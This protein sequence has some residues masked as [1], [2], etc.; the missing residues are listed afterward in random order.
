MLTN[1][2][3]YIRN[4]MILG[5]LT[6]ILVISIIWWIAPYF[7]MDSIDSIA[8]RWEVLWAALAIS[9][10]P[11]VALIAR[12]ASLRFFG[13]A[14]DGDHLD[15][16]VELDARV[17]NNTYEQYL[18]FAIALFGLTIGLP[19]THLAMPILLAVAFDFYRLL[20]W[21]GYGKNPIMRAYGFA[22][23]FYSNIMLLLL[24]AFLI[25]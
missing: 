24:C 25:I 4:R 14:I 1:G 19:W 8:G 6:S 21:L 7:Q 22:T 17:L 23:T 2:Q 11:I 20:F 3:R 16:Q 9:I 18:L 5:L 12:I 15:S 10:I 13:A